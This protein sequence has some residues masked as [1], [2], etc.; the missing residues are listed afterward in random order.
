MFGKKKFYEKKK[1]L[2]YTPYYFPEPFPINS[3]VSELSKREEIEGV[4]VVT[5]LPN[6][7][8]YKFY[9]GFN[10]L[11]PYK[12]INNKLEIIRL[13]VI[14]RYSNSKLAILSFYFSFFF[15]SFLF[16]A[17][18][19]LFNRNKFNHLITFC[20]SP[21]YVGY[22]GYLCGKLLGTKTSQWVQDIWPEAIESTIGIK[23]KL[24]KNVILKLQNFMWNFCDIL[25]AESDALT[26]HLQKKYNDKKVVTLFNPIRDEA[27]LNQ[28]TEIVSNKTI[29]ISYVGNIGKAQNIELILKSFIK[30]GITN[31]ILN[32]CGDGSIFEKLKNK[33]RNINIKWHGW[34]SG[35]KLNNILLTSDYYILSLNTIGRQGLIIPSKLQTYFMNKKPII[36][37]SKGAVRDLVKNQNAGLTCNDLNEDE[38]A[39]MFKTALK[40]GRHE[41]ELMGSNGYDFYVKNFT[42]NKI[43]D[44]FLL[45]I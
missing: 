26:N 39:E 13:P 22:I 40:L 23:N 10:I 41:R 15:S 25:F 4:T 16:L 27:N 43:V 38:I 28:S 29:N 3:F 21:V 24:L 37:I 33:Y 19:S 45:H 6:Y 2:I 31:S 9:K 44:K 35:D 36:C 14:P 42:K 20:G 8:N 11:G 34:I 7:R 17:F 5:S 1:I 30:S 12:E 18:Y 32:I